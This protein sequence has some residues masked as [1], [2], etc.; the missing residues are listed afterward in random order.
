MKTIKVE[1]VVNKNLDTVWDFWNDPKHITQWAFASD[2]WECPYAENDPKTDGTF[3]TRMAAK[4]KSTSFDF[5]GTYTSVVPKVKM[6][7]TISD[8][9]T[10]SVYFEKVSDDFTKIIEE[11]EMETV[12]SEDLQRAG[13]QAILENFKKHVEGTQGK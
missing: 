4:D 7:Y 5:T 2:D 6:D 1:V 10:V 12:N 11:F 9:R 3:L 8:G 13:W